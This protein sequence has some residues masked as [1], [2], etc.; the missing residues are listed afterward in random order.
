MI[1]PTLWQSRYMPSPSNSISFVVARRYIVMPSTLATDA[2]AAELLNVRYAV[3]VDLPA[4]CFLQA[5]ADGM[6]GRALR[7]RRIFKQPFLLH[8]AVMDAVDLKD[9]L[10]QRA[11]LVKH[12]IF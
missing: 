2:L 3:A 4:V 11:G 6:G 12:D 7:Q 1:V 5:L 9:A 10:R 8:L